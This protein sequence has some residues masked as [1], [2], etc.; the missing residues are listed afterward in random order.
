LIDEKYVDIPEDGEDYTLPADQSVI[1][2]P[3]I[4]K[5]EVDDYGFA[6]DAISEQEKAAE[7]AFRPPPP[8]KVSEDVDYQ[9]LTGI[10]INKK[11]DDQTSQKAGDDDEDY[12]DI[13]GQ[14]NKYV[15]GRVIG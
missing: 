1:G 5:D 10:D 3:P 11:P 8:P 4:S 6:K 15:E 13:T 2:V 12:S 7:T 9:D 14:D